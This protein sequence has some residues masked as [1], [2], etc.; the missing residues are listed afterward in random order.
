VTLTA[1]SAQHFSDFRVIISDQTEGSN[2]LKAGEV[3]AAIRLLRLRHEVGE[4]KHLPRKGMAEQRNFLL[5]LAS[6]PYALFLD[7][8]LVL[9]P[10]VIEIM[11][12]TIQEEGCGFVGCAPIGLSY[13]DD[14][15]PEEEH[16]EFWEGRVRPEEILPHGEAWQRHKLH[17]AA[18]IYHVQERLKLSPDKPR[19]YRVAWVGG[20]IMYD[21]DKLLETGGF[22]FWELLPPNHAGE[23]IVAQL[24]LMSKYGGCGIMP[25]GVYHQELP[26]TVPDRTY[27][28]PNL[29]DI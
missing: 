13:L 19:K 1:L 9:D 27:D 2:V 8:D 23:E 29:I 22:A 12:A 6:S 14:M 21:R 5:G 28:A 20:C 24:R 26:T 17:N 16:V 18:N 25:S 11:V 7:D 10:W 3:R 15:R 4:Y